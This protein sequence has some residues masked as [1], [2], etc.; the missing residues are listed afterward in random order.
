MKYG[1][2]Y[3]ETMETITEECRLTLSK[4]NPESVDE[5]VNVLLAAEK[6]F[7]IGVGRVMLSLEAMTKRFAHL[8]VNT[9]CVGQITEPAITN[10]DA[11]IVGS[12]S[13]ESVIPVSI[14]KIAKKYGAK[15]IYIGSNPESTMAGMADVFVRIPARSKLYLEDETESVQ[16]MT[17]LFEQSLLLFGDTVA[18]LIIDKNNINIKEL[19]QCHANLE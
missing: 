5:F 4:V 17:S 18:K 12:G 16:P 6:V 2:R 8:G 1:N 11:L 13:G 10:A 14:A 15:I 3:R 9:V 19:W 7:F